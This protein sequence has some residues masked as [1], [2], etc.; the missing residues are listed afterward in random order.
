M[1]TEK[2]IKYY[3]K[4]ING[5][6]QPLKI[7]DNM[8]DCY[9]GDYCIDNKI[10][11]T[12]FI[13]KIRD[14]AKI[15]CDDEN[16]RMIVGIL[17]ED[18]NLFFSLA[19]SSPMGNDI[20]AEHSLIQTLH[21]YEVEK[22]KIK[23]KLLQKK[24]P[25]LICINSRGIIKAPCGICRELLKHYLPNT[26]VILKNDILG[27]DHKNQNQND[28]IMIKSKFLLPYPYISSSKIN[29]E[30]IMLNGENIIFNIE[31]IS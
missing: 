18:G 9:S 13:Q 15:Y 20:H 12:L 28:L 30:S 25:I 6:N 29:P 17:C 10:N 16:F 8:I 1:F 11:I 19:T 22:Y 26:Y 2:F 23:N 21:K 24:Y 27:N 31:E 14:L 4:N 7:H 3:N 5:G